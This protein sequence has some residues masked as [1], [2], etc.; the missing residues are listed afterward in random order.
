[1]I[2]VVGRSAAECVC[3]DGFGGAWV[4]GRKGVIDEAI[5]WTMV[6]LSVVTTAAL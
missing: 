2:E 3:S 4:D 6:K 5:H 1:M